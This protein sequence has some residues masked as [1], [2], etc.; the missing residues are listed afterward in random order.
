[1]SLVQL[2]VFLPQKRLFL[3]VLHLLGR[4]KPR[5]APNEALIF[6]TRLEPILKLESCWLIS[7]N[8]KGF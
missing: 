1:M 5:N 8:F 3:K 4:S 6:M 2:Q 7:T